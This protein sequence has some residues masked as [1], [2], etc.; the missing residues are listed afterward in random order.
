MKDEIE[1]FGNQFSFKSFLFLSL[2]EKYDFGKLSN[3]VG[4]KLMENLSIDNIM[5]VYESIDRFQK[6]EMM[7]TICSFIENNTLLIVEHENFVHIH[8]NT[9]NF[10]LSQSNLNVCEIQLFNACLRWAKAEATNEQNLIASPAQLREALG[11]ELFLVRIPTMSFKHFLQGPVASGLFDVDEQNQLLKYIGAS[12]KPEDATSDFVAR[13]ELNGRNGGESVSLNFDE[14]FKYLPFELKVK[15][16][17]NILQFKSSDDFLLHGFFF[18]RVS[19]PFSVTCVQL[20]EQDSSQVFFQQQMPYTTIKEEDKNPTCFTS[21]FPSPLLISANYTYK[22]T[23]ILELNE[24][25]TN[26]HEVVRE[27]FTMQYDRKYG[28]SPISIEFENI[29]RSDLNIYNLNIY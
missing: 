13:F 15:D 17:V 6:P 23:L 8:R 22:L 19:V 18:G 29:T 4:M 12:V 2:A 24:I 27:K 5:E 11:D 3:L 7:K 21:C 20:V 25:Q 14:N 9:L 10:V 28:K 16:A 1:Y 26:S